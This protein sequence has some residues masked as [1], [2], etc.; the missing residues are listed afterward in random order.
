MEIN[1]YELLYLSREKDEEAFNMLLELYRP[2]F[3]KIYKEVH[4]RGDTFRIDDAM[5]AAAIGLYHAI[6]YYREDK[7]MAFHNFVNLCVTREMQAWRRKEITSNYLGTG[8]VLSLDYVLKD[9][10]NIQ[11][12]DLNLHFERKDNVEVIAMTRCIID[13][14]F[15]IYP[16]NSTEGQLL[17]LRM[18]GFSYNDISEKL[19]MT[20]K[21]VDNCY[22]KI[23]KKLKHLFD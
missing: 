12:Q 3:Y 17:I 16:K 13:E 4:S 11:Y 21:Q 14:I 8:A 9:S 23:K 15:K 19:N 2:M 1:E 22:Q 7:N 5:Q 10:E 6:Y 18:R 20:A